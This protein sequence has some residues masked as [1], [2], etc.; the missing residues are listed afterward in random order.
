MDREEY[1]GVGV[2]VW[3]CW[4]GLERIRWNSGLGR[5]VFSSLWTILRAEIPRIPWGRGA[6]RLFCMR[7]RSESCVNGY[8]RFCLRC[9]R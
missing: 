2:L 5:G 3:T 6:L 4:V 7:W 9:L 8:A 1:V